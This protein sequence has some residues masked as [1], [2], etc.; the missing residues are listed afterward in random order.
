MAMGR[1][2]GEGF[3][4]RG[5]LAEFG[6]DVVEAQLVAEEIGGALFVPVGPAAVAAFAELDR[7]RA[8]AHVV[9]QKQASREIAVLPPDSDTPNSARPRPRAWWLFVSGRTGVDPIPAAA[10]RAAAVAGDA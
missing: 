1:R 6:T 5:V 2:F 8:Q 4:I 9:A 10:Q 3:R 7:P